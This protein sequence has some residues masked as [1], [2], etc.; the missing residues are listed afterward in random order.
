M[1]TG[2]VTGFDAKLAA[3]ELIAALRADD[4]AEPAIEGVARLPTAEAQQGL[5]S[6]ALTPNRPLA[7]R[8][9][10]ADA[11]ARHVQAFG[12]LTPDVLTNTVATQA[13]TETDPDL[14]G[15]LIVLRG[16]LAPSPAGFVAGLRNYNPPLVPPPMPA[17]PP[18]P[19]NPNPE[20]K[21]EPKS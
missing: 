1:A 20:P 10:A 4:L 9:R 16:L 5:V 2:E 12:R 15:R 8:A 7:L 13:G 6:L 14:R 21:T 17:M 3:A 18:M 19:A 11:A